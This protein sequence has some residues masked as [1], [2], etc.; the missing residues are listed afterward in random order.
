MMSYYITH[1]FGTHY[2]GPSYFIGLIPFVVVIS[3]IIFIEEFI[4]CGISYIMTR[5]EIIRLRFIL[6]SINASLFIIFLVG[7]GILFYN[8]V[9]LAKE[10]PELQFFLNLLFF[11]FYLGLFSSGVYILLVLWTRTLDHSIGQGGLNGLIFGIILVFS[12]DFIG[13]EHY[14]KIL[15]ILLF[16]GLGLLWGLL[17]RREVIL[18]KWVLILFPVEQSVIIS[19]IFSV[20]LMWLFRALYGID[21]ENERFLSLL[22]LILS[23]IIVILTSIY[24]TRLIRTEPFENSPYRKGR[25]LKLGLLIFIFFG[26]GGLYS[27]L[28]I[29]MKP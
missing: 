19:L 6:A 28:T 15:V 9:Y 11:L 8:N 7:T 13:L 14:D 24:L 5:N 27:L 23:T 12:L 20:F 3:L 25:Y 29:E 4:S 16:A 22:G 10:V 2:D 1:I 21:F 17:G 26:I 18:Q